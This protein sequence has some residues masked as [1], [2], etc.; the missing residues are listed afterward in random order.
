MT[1]DFMKSAGFHVKSAG[2]HVKS[3]GF[4]VKSAGF[5]NM[6]FCVMT[7]Y[8]SFFRKTNHYDF[9]IEMFNFDP[10]VACINHR[11]NWTVWLVHFACYLL[12]YG[13]L[14]T[15]CASVTGLML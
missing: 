11:D 14:V 8:R 6:S 13:N 3:A 1:Q 9:Q 12:K 15:V 5:Q 7:R 4:H 10:L 2:F